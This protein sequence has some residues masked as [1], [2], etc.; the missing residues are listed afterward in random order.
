MERAADREQHA[1]LWSGVGGK[2]E[3]SEINHPHT[4]CLR[5]VAEET[6]LAPSDVQGLTL[7]YVM[8]RRYKEIIRQSYIYFGNTQKSAVTDTD[9]GTL[10]WVPRE[11]L[12]DKTFSSTYAQ[13]LGHSLSSAA[14]DSCI[15]VG[16]AENKDEALRVCWAKI[17]DFI[18]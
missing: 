4:A 6:G 12:I 13:M 10:H 9:E 5:E 11:N 8:L 17:Q 2:M 3:P 7:R 18:D 14:D 15:F 1:T 16:T